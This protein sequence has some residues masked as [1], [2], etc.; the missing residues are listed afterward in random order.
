MD[1]DS[2][3]SQEIEFDSDV[4][5]ISYYDA[6]DVP[7]VKAIM[8]VCNNILSQTPM[9]STLYFLFAS[10]GGSVDAGIA[11]Y[12]YLKSLPVKIVMHNTGSIDSI[13]NVICVGGQERYAAPHSTC[14]RDD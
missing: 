12:N 14:P 1:K 2:D 10:Q 8:T 7:H 11:L 5:Y 4:F 13:A 9:P 3:N 6:I